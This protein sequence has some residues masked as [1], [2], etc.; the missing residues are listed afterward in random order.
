MRE[1]EWEHRKMKG[2]VTGRRGLP[3]YCA[4]PVGQGVVGGGGEKTE[5]KARLAFKLATKW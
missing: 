3:G 1:V 2:H 4:A 5:E